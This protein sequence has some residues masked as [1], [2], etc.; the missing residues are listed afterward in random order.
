MN[1]IKL[2]IIS[3]WRFLKKVH[4]NYIV[5]S[6]F[7]GISSF[8]WLLNALGK[9]YT[10]SV[11][12]T[13]EY[14]NIPDNFTSVESSQQQIM[15]EQTGSGYSFFKYYIFD[16]YFVIPIDVNEYVTDTNKNSH[17]IK[18]PAYDFL[19]KN[20]SELFEIHSVEPQTIS[21]TIS[22]IIQKKVPVRANL[23]ITC[24]DNFGFTAPNILEPDSIELEGAKIVLDTVQYVYTELL[25]REDL[26]SSFS[27][28]LNLVPIPGVKFEKSYIQF[29]SEVDEKLFHIIEV[30]ID[31]SLVPE[32]EQRRISESVVIISY[33]IFSTEYDEDMDTVMKA[34]ANYTKNS[35]KEKRIP[36]SIQNVPEGISILS[37]QPSELTYFNFEK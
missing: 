29:S 34:V 2:K 28:S 36:I 12:Y 20:H 9:T 37:V 27:V 17:K 14:Q 18:I 16:T 19:A 33:A 30:P 1:T 31:M 7:F 24:K 3:S 8:F 15:V 6:L 11:P 35:K 22:R 21:N 5:F 23:S 13:L 26:S 4:P 10:L 25:E 32:K